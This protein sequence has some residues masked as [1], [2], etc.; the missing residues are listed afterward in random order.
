MTYVAIRFKKLTTGNNVFNVSVIVYSNCYIL[1]FLRQMFN[2]STLLLDD[3][4]KPATPLTN[5]MISET[6]RQFAQLSDISQG[7]VAAH[8]RCGGIFSNGMYYCKFFPDSDS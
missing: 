1:Q 4:F 8:L 2:V 7:S 3:A 5:G 6:L